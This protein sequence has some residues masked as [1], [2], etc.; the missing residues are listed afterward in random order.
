M[1]WSNKL[2]CFLEPILYKNVLINVLFPFNKLD[3]YCSLV[4]LVYN[5]ETVW[6]THK[7]N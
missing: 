2:E 6:L 1:L 7:S 5:Y 4:K 3:R